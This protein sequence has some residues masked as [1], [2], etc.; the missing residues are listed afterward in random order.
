[1]NTIVVDGVTR[2]FDWVSHHDER[3]RNYPAMALCAGKVPKSRTWGCKLYLDQGDK[4]ACTGH[5]VAHEGAA[6]PVVIPDIT[7]AVAFELYDRAQELD[8]WPGKN[9]PGS[10][11][12]AAMKA[13]TERGWY[14]GGYRWAFG[15]DD[16]AVSVPALGPAVL[17]IKWTKDMCTPDAKGWIHATGESVGGHAILCVGYNLKK[18]AFRLHNSWGTSWGYNGDCWISRADLG[19]LLKDGGEAAI[20]LK[21]LMPVRALKRSG[22]RKTRG[23]K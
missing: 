23:T 9:Y 6:Q 10:S 12:T 3:S 22:V 2:V 14:E 5:A 17:G 13:G 11:V 8:E 7:S 21:R 16:L 15:V 1:M 19:K 4:P 20:P 18:D